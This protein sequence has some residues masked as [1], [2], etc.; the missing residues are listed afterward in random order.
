MKKKLIQIALISMVS[1]TITAGSLEQLQKGTISEK[2]EIMHEMGYAGNKTG[3]WYFVKYLN[4]ETEYADEISAAKCRQ[5]AAEALGRIRDDRA[6]PHLVKRYKKE[7]NI[8]VKRSIMFAL[9]YYKDVSM[10]EAVLDGIKSDDI[11][12]KF[13]AILAAEKIE[14]DSITS[15]ISS[16]YESAKEGEIKATCA[17]VLFKKTNS[18]NYYK[19][20]LSALEETNPD[21][22]YWTSHYLGEIS[23]KDSAEYIAKAIEIESIYWVRRKMEEVLTKIYFDERDRRRI[24]EYNKYE[25]LIK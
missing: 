7:K 24:S 1:L 17:Y 2:I 20:L 10:V 11:D 21:T 15:A 22:R 4:H 13:Q 19:H 25:K 18:E 12:L 6:I 9:R 3:F 14:D 5:A 16:Q 23:A 8:A